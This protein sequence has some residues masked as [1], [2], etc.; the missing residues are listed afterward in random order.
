ML[1][2]LVRFIFFILAFV[3]LSF[4]SN[5]IVT[6]IS[7]FTKR[8]RIP[9]FIFSFF[10]VGML[11]SVGEI[12]VAINAVS[13]HEPEIFVGSL[14]GGTLVIFSLVIPLAAILARGIH[15]KKH[16]S[17][18]SLLYILG[19]IA[20]P[21]LFTLDHKISN[22]EAAILVGLYLSLFFVVRAPHGALRKVEAVFKKERQTL[23]ENTLLRIALGGIIVFLSSR[24][25][26]EQ[27]VVYSHHFHISAF[28]VSLIIIAIGMNLPEISLAFRAALSKDAKTE[29]IAIGDF[30]GSA[31]ANVLIFGVFSLINNGDVI[32]A[33]SFASTFLF[34]IIVLGSFFLFTRGKSRLT[35]REGFGL[36]GLYILFVGYRFFIG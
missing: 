19:V 30:L 23:R 8:V 33:K 14:L 2:G 4:G 28:V 21:A 18:R 17:S 6:T 7:Q 11:T 25:L 34:V 29:D 9:P 20:T 1:M 3:F 12:A 16:L 24:Y 26:V 22:P 36:A 10:I 13:I 31:A 32:T 35:P 15:V 27:T 5:M